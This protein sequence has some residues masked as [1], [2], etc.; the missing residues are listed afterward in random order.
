MLPAL[1]E[2]EKQRCSAILDFDRALRAASE[3]GFENAVRLLLDA[4]ASI[5]HRDRHGETALHLASSGGYEETVQL[6]LRRRA[7][8]N[9]VNVNYWNPLQEASVRGHEEVV[10]LLLDGGANLRH[11]N[12]DGD[13]ALHLASGSGHVNIVRLLLD[14][15]ADLGTPGRGSGTVLLRASASGQKDVVNILLQRGA[16]MEKEGSAALIGA[17]IGGREDM[18]D[19]WLNKGVEIDSVQK[20]SG[21]NALQAA[22]QYGRRNIVQLLLCRGAN[23]NAT[24][25]DDIGTAL[26]AACGSKDEKDETVQLLLDYD[27]DVNAPGG[28]NGTALE[29]ASKW[30]HRKIV[31]L[32]L[33]RHADVRSQGNKALILASERGFKEI[34][35]LLLDAGADI[36]ASDCLALRS[37]LTTGHVDVTTSAYWEAHDI[38]CHEE[39]RTRIRESARRYIDLAQMF[40]NRGADTDLL[41]GL[42]RSR[43]E[44]WQRLS[45]N[46]FPT[47]QSNGSVDAEASKILQGDQRGATCE[48]EPVRAPLR[49]TDSECTDVRLEGTAETAMTESEISN[50]A[51][52]STVTIRQRKKSVL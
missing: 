19:F 45:K 18:V 31:Q 29:I 27:V 6:L 17:C 22:C 24:A 41:D 9:I 3:K 7:N 43:L 42:E 44:M 20:E 13:T 35:E 49:A 36:N 30:G 23:V 47:P 37:T 39:K 52:L 26:Q 34:A 48:L 2:S 32:L 14:R 33:G 21:E 4:G 28:R 15:G 12:Q 46:I 25:G 11:E 1:I 51:A 50:A 10:R 8:V 38:Q 40:V 5:D 16:N